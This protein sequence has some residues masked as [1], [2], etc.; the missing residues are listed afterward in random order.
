MPHG[1]GVASAQALVTPR[2]SFAP[3]EDA[4]I[5]SVKPVTLSD[6]S[7]AGALSLLAATAWLGCEPMS[8]EDPGTHADAGLEMPSD[9]GAGATSGGDDR[10]REE[11]ARSDGQARAEPARNDDRAGAEREAET[12]GRSDAC[13]GR[14][15]VVVAGSSNVVAGSG[16]ISQRSL[17]VA[18]AAR[19]RVESPFRAELTV[20]PRAMGDVELRVRAD[21]DVLPFV[22]A[23]ER[24]GALVLGLEPGAY[25]LT[26][27]SLEAT[28]GPLQELSAR[29]ASDVR[30]RDVRAP[31][32]TLSAEDTS[33][34]SASGQ[35]GEWRVRLQDASRG[36]LTVG[37]ASLVEL[38]LASASQVSIEGSVEETRVRAYAASQLVAT[39]PGFRTQRARVELDGLARAELC[40][41]DSVS[42]AVMGLAKLLVQCGG[43]VQV[44]GSAVRK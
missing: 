22:V 20:D 13:S 18:R 2:L 23:E 31:L 12:S 10:A 34:I 6:S 19:W 3:R 38:E 42:G 8:P 1:V 7:A 29:A 27:L 15:N 37:S 40:V 32:V 14:A 36:A 43:D 25:C 26:E 16:V 44:A 33:H 35:A 39:A 17:S 4:M 11:P 5:A 28:I 9:G 21:D 30:V 24:D 41:A